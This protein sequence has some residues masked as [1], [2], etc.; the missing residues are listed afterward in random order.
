MLFLSVFYLIIDVAG[1][2]KWAFPFV[3]IG[4]NSILIYLAS[5]G[6]VDFKYTANYFFGGI[7]QYADIVWQPVF[8]AISI[9]LIQLVLLYFLYRN[10]VFLKI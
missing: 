7:I 2:R 5:E 3:L 8:L 9:T 10:K 6:M 4:V 1:Y